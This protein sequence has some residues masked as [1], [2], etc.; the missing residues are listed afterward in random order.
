M[1]RRAD[2]RGLVSF[3]I[4]CAAAIVLAVS[5][6]GPRTAWCHS[7]EGAS[8]TDTILRDTEIE[9]DIRTLA[10]PVWR[11]A[12]LD[13]KSVGDIL[14][15]GEQLLH[16]GGGQQPRRHG[17][18]QPGKQGI[19]RDRGKRL[20]SGGPG[21]QRGRVGRREEGDLGRRRD[22]ADLVPDRPAGGRRGQVPFL[23]AQAAHQAVEGLAFGGQVGENSVQGHDDPLCRKGRTAGQAVRT[24]WVNRARMFLRH[25]S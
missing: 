25:N 4:F 2:G 18:G 10:T 5:A 1:S 23:R 9:N 17:P 19:R 24:G 7:G 3:R 6:L 13:P 22:V 15:V 21:G 11:V 20:G 16:P 8:A 14:P 12:G